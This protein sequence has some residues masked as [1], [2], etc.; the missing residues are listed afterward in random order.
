VLLRRS[1]LGYPPRMTAIARRWTRA[2]FQVLIALFV[3]AGIPEGA[4][5]RAEEIQ[6]PFVRSRPPAPTYPIDWRVRG[7]EGRVGVTA[8]IDTS[9]NVVSARPLPGGSVDTDSAAVAN[10][11]L[12]KFHPYR[13]K[14]VQ[15][16]LEI[17]FAHPM[18]PNVIAETERVSTGSGWVIDSTGRRVPLR[19]EVFCASQLDSV[20]G[21]LRYRYGLT[22]I[23]E[24]EAAALYLA[25]YPLDKE[26]VSR[27]PGPVD[28]PLV[29]T[30][31]AGFQGCSDHIDVGGWMKSAPDSGVQ[32]RGLQPGHTVSGL[33]F[34]SP[35]WPGRGHWIAGGGRG[36][37]PGC[38]PWAD[39]CSL[40]ALLSG[41]IAVPRE[42]VARG[43]ISGQVVTDNGYPIPEARVAVLGAGRDTTAAVNGYFFIADLPI[44]RFRVRATAPGVEPAESWVDIIPGHAYVRDLK[45]QRTPG[46]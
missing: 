27:L 15:L 12:W 30:G 37:G 42:G 39:S 19:V 3:S 36:C 23:R 46:K 25:L 26:V 11:R 14:P 33:S 44:G 16:R 24:S 8:T 21:L 32:P 22:N 6:G 1:P 4:Q 20:T 13:G 28:E 29:S 2:F 10:A 5:G 7:F 9:G 40:N 45:L 35:R 34:I 43:S 18:S 41:V 17:P 31:W 38:F